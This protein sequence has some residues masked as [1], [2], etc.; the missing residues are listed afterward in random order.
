[1]IR[2]Q[3]SVRWRSRAI[4]SAQAIPI[5]TTDTVA[6]AVIKLIFIGFVTDIVKYLSHL[7]RNEHKNGIAFG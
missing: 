4:N 2:V 7:T 5:K 1:M 6:V 3:R